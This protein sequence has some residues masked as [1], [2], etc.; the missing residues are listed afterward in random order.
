MGEYRQPRRRL[1]RREGFRPTTPNTMS[2]MGLLAVVLVVASHPWQLD[3]ASLAAILAAGGTAVLA[4]FTWRLARETRLLAHETEEDVRAEWRPVLITPAPLL[5]GTIGGSNFAT[6]QVRLD[7]VGRGPALNTSVTL[8][9]ESSVD[10]AAS[11]RFSFGTITQGVSVMVVVPEMLFRDASGGPQSTLKYTL[12]A[13]YEDLSGRVHESDIV[14]VDPA[15]GQHRRPTISGE[16]SEFQVEPT[17]TRVSAASR[18][19]AA[20]PDREPPR[21]EPPASIV[22]E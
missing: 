22:Y 7:N 15:R 8:S 4:F 2:A 18:A 9:S 6:T 1:R 20:P 21:H 19:G 10:S 3:M 13:T 16:K 5:V 14:Y 11:E 17:H 12:G